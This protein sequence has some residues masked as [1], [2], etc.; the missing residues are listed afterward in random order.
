MD[1]LD[2]LSLVKCPCLPSQWWGNSRGASWGLQFSLWPALPSASQLRWLVQGGAWAS[3]GLIMP[4]VDPM[5]AAGRGP[6]R[7]WADR[8]V[9]VKV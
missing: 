3:A 8:K 5:G 2:E 4:A 6:G 9:K 7:P 1:E